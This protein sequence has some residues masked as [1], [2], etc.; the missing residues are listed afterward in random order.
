MRAALIYSTL[1]GMPASVTE[2]E[3]LDRIR[4][5]NADPK[6]HG[7]LVQ[8][9]LPAHI[10]SHKVIEAIAAENDVDGFHVANAGEL[11]TGRPQLRPCTPYRVVKMLGAGGVSAA[12]KRAV[13]IGR[14]N[15]VGA[16]GVVAA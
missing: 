3:L 16:D 11:M 4:E 1:D 5:L 2:H 8:L 9:P 14:S 12:G 7:I 10:D 15:I 6:I 13:V